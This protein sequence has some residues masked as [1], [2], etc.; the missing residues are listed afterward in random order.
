MGVGIAVMMDPPG[1]SVSTVVTIADSH[2]A[3]SRGAG[4]QF[5]GHVTACLGW[6]H[7]L[8]P[9]SAATS[10]CVVPNLLSCARLR[11]LIAV[12]CLQETVSPLGSTL[13]SVADYGGG[14]AA[15][16]NPFGDSLDTSYTMSNTTLVNNTASTCRVHAR[17]CDHWLAWNWAECVVVGGTPT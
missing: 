2:F 14:F 15:Y 17:C 12:G 8:V 9:P 16:L 10:T 11:T 6:A 4:A 3:G 1:N 5:L 7:S 13:A